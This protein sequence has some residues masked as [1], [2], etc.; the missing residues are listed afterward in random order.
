[1][2]AQY[3]DHNIIICADDDWK[4]DGN[5]GVTA[6]QQV[7]HA[8]DGR[9]AIP[10]FGKDRSENETDFN[11]MLVAEGK[12]AV[13]DAID[14]ASAPEDEDDDDSEDGA[15][16]HGGPKQSDVLIDLASAADLFHDDSIGYADIDVDGHREILADPVQRFP[17]V[18]VA[19]L[20]QAT[21]QRPVQ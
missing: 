6:A 1:M 3:P 18:A 13:K 9:V 2:H 7:A 12:E 17:R 10:K 4:S 21:A 8:V 11:D 16:H 19:P 20:L 15:A 5:P 14:A